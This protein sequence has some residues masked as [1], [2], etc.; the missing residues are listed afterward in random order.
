MSQPALFSP[1]YQSVTL[2]SDRPHCSA[3][4]SR[5]VQQLC[6]CFWGH[7]FIELLTHSFCSLARYMWGRGMEAPVG[8][9]Q[10]GASGQGREVLAKDTSAPAVSLAMQHTCHLPGPPTGKCLQ[11]SGQEVPAAV[12]TTS[13]SPRSLP[14]PPAGGGHAPIFCVHFFPPHST[15][16]HDSSLS[17]P[18][19]QLCSCLLLPPSWALF[20]PAPV[21]PP[22]MCLCSEEG[23]C[24]SWVPW[25]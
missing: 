5:S 2:A 8:L 16:H 22:Q 17:K 12:S 10:V 9:G 13:S 20:S 24:S 1:T 21:Y 7:C 4:S 19:L 18:W 25:V 3:R 14:G 6:L 15:S 23:L 11:R